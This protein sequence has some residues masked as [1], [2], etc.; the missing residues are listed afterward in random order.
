MAFRKKA[1][2]PMGS[3]VGTWLEWFEEGTE[4]ALEGAVE[5]AEPGTAEP[6]N[7]EPGNEEPGN[8][9]PGSEEPVG[10]VQPALA[11][12]LAFHDLARRFKGF[13][14]PV[15]S[16]KSV[17]L[18]Q[19]A[20]RLSVANPGRLGLIGAPTYPMLQD[21][22]Q[23]I[24]FEVLEQNKIEYTF[25]KQRN[26]LTLYPWGSEIIF[27][28]LDHP[29]SLRGTNL[30]WF[31]VDELTYCKEEAFLRLQARL[32]DPEAS[33][34]CG[35]GTWTPKG[36]DWVHRLFVEANNSDYGLV[37]AS[38]RENTYLPDDFYD[39]LQRS[40]SER[41]YR[42]EAL[43][44]YL[45]VFSGQAY[46]AFD[47]N[48]Q[49]RNMSYKPDHPIWWALD[50][51]VNPMCSLIG[52]TINGVV[53][54]LDEIVMA[55]SHT[56]ACCEEF[57]A[58]S[59]K[60]LL[61]REIPDDLMD[62][63]EDL[64]QNAVV[65]NRPVPLMVYVYGDATGT[66][67]KT[68]ASRTDWQIAKAFFGRYADRFKVQFRVPAGNGP[69]KDRVNCVNAMLLNY[70]GQRRLFLT[71]NCRG[72]VTDFEQ[73]VWKADPHGVSL[74]ELDKRDPMRSHLSDALGYYIVREFPM[75]RP[76]G[77]RGGTAVI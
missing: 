22:T 50:F 7:E 38:P 8:G 41:F 43:G 69:V 76:S 10:Y 3:Q 49:V 33:E 56:L 54:V 11:G 37:R 21:V 55:N 52:Q 48:A 5:T 1:P 66:Q 71:P 72:L 74:S 57:L 9:E 65:M 51:N 25:H 77:E 59:E 58:R 75:H 18:V 61:M 46:H 73:L 60:W 53:R 29:E 28:S 30:A 14:G 6:G 68:A 12:Q 17:A 13:S 32:R 35:F 70:A 31:G 16:G 63:D 44:E 24:F 47:R 42:Q 40:Y 20:L 23:R 36:F 39:Q 2:L 67:R 26:H 64:I 15:G 4:E 62:I 45:N 34:L 19:E 27:R